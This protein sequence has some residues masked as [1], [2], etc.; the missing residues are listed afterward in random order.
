MTGALAAPLMEFPAGQ[1][2]VL[3]MHLCLRVE[4]HTK[5]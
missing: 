2:D 3:L 1:Q 5:V 4:R